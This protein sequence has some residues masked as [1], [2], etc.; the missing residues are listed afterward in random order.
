MFSL[1]SFHFDKEK[2]GQLLKSWV[3]QA[4]LTYRQVESLTQIPYDTL[5]NCLAGRIQDIKFE[6]VFKVAVVT[7][8]SVNEYISEMFQEV[9]VDFLDQIIDLQPLSPAIVSLDACDTMPVPVIAQQTEVT[10][11]KTTEILAPS[12]TGAITLHDLNDH[13]HIIRQEHVDSLNRFKSVHNSYV[14]K[15]ENNYHASIARYERQIDIIN[16]EHAKAIHE[17]KE[18]HKETIAVLHKV[19]DKLRKRSRWLAGFLT[20]ETIAIIALFIVDACLPGIGWLRSLRA[21]FSAAPFDSM[22]S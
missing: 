6:V 15:L 14:E 3:K 1:A 16:Q 5:N 17:L 13:L 7:G 21:M 8:H 11:V 9:E 20:A 4:G 12:Q 19:A 2:S 22:R 10:T 18:S